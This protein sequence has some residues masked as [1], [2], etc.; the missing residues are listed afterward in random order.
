MGPRGPVNRS[1]SNGGS[2]TKAGRRRRFDRIETESA[3]FV[4]HLSHG[5]GCKTRSKAIQSPL[6]ASVSAN[7]IYRAALRSKRSQEAA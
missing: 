3:M 5:Q 6:A 7:V 2:R 1:A 4:W